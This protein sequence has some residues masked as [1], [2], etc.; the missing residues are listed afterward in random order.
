MF[1]QSSKA[2]KYLHMEMSNYYKVVSH[3]QPDIRLK[4]G[5]NNTTPFYLLVVPYTVVQLSLHVMEQFLR[6]VSLSLSFLLVCLNPTVL[7]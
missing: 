5:V 1:Q 2:C 7:F 3:L 6:A 4:C